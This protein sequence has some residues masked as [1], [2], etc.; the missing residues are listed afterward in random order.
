MTHRYQRR[1]RRNFA[2]HCALA[3]TLAALTG[4]ADPTSQPRASAAPETVQT[5]TAAVAMP[6]RYSAAAAERILRAG[7]NAVDAAIAAGFALAVTYPEAGNIGGGGFMLLRV[8]GVSEFIDYRETAPAAASADMFLDADGEVIEG[9]TLTGHRAAGVPGTVAGFWLAHQRAGTLPWARLLE[10]AIELARDG[11]EVHPDLAASYRSAL[12]R[13]GEIEPGIV[14]NLRAH[15]GAMDAGDVLKQPALAATLGRVSR[16]GPEDFYRG[17]TAALI[18]AE[19]RRNGGL[20]DAADLARYTAAVR[21]PL[22]ARWRDYEVNTAPPPSSGGI[23]LLQLLKMR[24][25]LGDAFAGLA[26]NSAQYVHLIAEIEKRV[27]ADRAEY[28]GDPDFISVPV[29]RLVADDYIE[30]RAAEVDRHAISKLEAIDPGLESTDTTHYSVVDRW[31]NAVANTYTINFGFGNGVVVADAGFLLNNEMDDF[32]AKPGVPNIFGV[33]G[34]DANA[35]APG[36]RMLSSMTPTLLLRDGRTAMVLGTPGGSTIFTTV[37]QTL[38]N[39]LDFDM[40]AQ[41]AA[42]A[43]RFHHQLLPPD[44]ISMSLELPDETQRQLRARGYRVEPNSWGIYGDMQLLWR[45]E[46]GWDAGSDA[47]YR[48]ESRVIGG[49]W[50]AAD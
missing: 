6:D 37:F 12:R 33:V 10:P 42:S 15:F 14:V 2:L 40:S 21:E 27:F 48:G 43:P 5:G 22:V 41:E 32:S 28:L 1:S 13:H 7:G 47:R 44:L 49:P 8:D 25:A 34:A 20:I 9:S 11:F 16:D 45:R 46:D 23:A 4:C 17:R 26:H 3:A 50:T 18:A 29:T 35:I 38:L 39:A 24:D 36:K 30:R 19:M 31:G